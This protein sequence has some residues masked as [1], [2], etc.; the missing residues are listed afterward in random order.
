M[1][2][3]T[4]K[5]EI[6][7]QA[8]VRDTFSIAKIGTIAGCLVTDGTINRNSKARLIR[9]GIVI[10]TTTINSL[11]RFKDDAREVS[12]GYECGIMLD[13]FNDLKANDIIETYKEVEE[14]V[15]I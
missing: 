14:K 7:G 10:Y 11:K 2:T 15:S 8:E 13:N 3:P 4:I 1:M 6:S 5:E 12:K 9:D